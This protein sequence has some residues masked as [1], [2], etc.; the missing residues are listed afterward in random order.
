MLTQVRKARTYF[1]E[2][3]KYHDIIICTHLKNHFKNVDSGSK[4]ANLFRRGAAD[5]MEHLQHCSCQLYH[6]GSSVSYHIICETVKT[7]NCFM[8]ALQYKL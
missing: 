5:F 2:A 3:P 6:G 7:V 8:A 1:N 4:S